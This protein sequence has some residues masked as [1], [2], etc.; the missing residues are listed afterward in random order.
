MIDGYKCMDCVHHGGP[1]DKCCCPL[2]CRNNDKFRAKVEK[3][4]K[5]TFELPQNPTPLQL[6]QALATCSNNIAR[7]SDLCAQYKADVAIKQT[8]LKRAMARALVKHSG[9][10]SATLAKA[11]AETDGDVEAAQDAVDQ[12]NA[13]YLVAQGEMDGY[14]AQFI[15]IRKIVN[16]RQ[17][18]MQT[19]GS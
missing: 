6:N 4:V 17:L 18:E 9:A 14:E 7:L 12:A 1:R 10:K 8:A 13:L 19:M 2:P 5:Q 3:P 15:A 16:I 11:L